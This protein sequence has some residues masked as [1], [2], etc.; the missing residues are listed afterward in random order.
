LALGIG[1]DLAQN[2]RRSEPQYA[3][4]GRMSV[5]HLTPHLEA[6][7]NAQ[8]AS[9]RFNSREDVIRAALALLEG[10]SP[11]TEMAQTSL[12]H[13][14]DRPAAS[15]SSAVPRSP[16]G[17]LADLHDHVDQ[18]DIEEAHREVWSRYLTGHAE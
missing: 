15:D 18:D 13:T 7:I 14:Y 4:L 11:P 16:R 1:G 6:F 8:L 9:G 12:S 3:R 5:V 17:L 10:K 2:Y